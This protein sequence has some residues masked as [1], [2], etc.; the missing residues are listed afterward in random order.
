MVG[1][2]ER[3][4][5][6]AGLAV[7]AVSM[8]TLS[9]TALA[10]TAHHPRTKAAAGGAEQ[11]CKIDATPGSFVD[12]GEFATSSSV[13]DV[14]EVECKPVFAEKKVTI[15]AQELYARCNH[16]L[17]WTTPPTVP[18][19]TGPAFG[20]TLDDDGN[21]IAVL[22]GGPSCAAGGSLV[23]AELDEAPYTT[24]TTE[25]TVLPP[26]PTAVGLRVEPAE[27][28]ESATNSSVATIVQVEFPPVYGEQYVNVNDR[29]LYNRCQE[30][31]RLSWVGPDEEVFAEGNFEPGAKKVRLD[32]DGNAFVVL[33]AGESCAAG[34]TLVEASLESAPYTTFTGTFTV[35][36]PKPSI[37]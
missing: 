33:L 32:D 3:R 11:V 13:A 24:V 26:Q 19:T 31:A 20:V 27:A 7:L 37:R 21:A 35:G 6:L 23:T 15:A 22:W 12:Q 8:L 5:L 18:V 4:S 29:E 14:V 9:D 25:F 10:R 16:E 1:V 28:T 2:T 17:S 36:A 34:P 30:G